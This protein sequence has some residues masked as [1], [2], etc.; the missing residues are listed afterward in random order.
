M[1]NRIKGAEPLFFV[2]KVT[3]EPCPTRETNGTHLLCTSTDKDHRHVDGRGGMSLPDVRPG[4]IWADNDYRMKG[5]KVQILE[6]IEIA[7]EPA[8]RV[9]VTAN[10]KGAVKPLRTDQP[11]TTIIRV[12]RFKPNATGFVLETDV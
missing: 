6:L 9:I 10:A 3:G 5:R 7:G 1:V 8:A 2:D 4:Q 12:R 11:R